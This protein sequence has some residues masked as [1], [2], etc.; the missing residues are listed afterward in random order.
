[1]SQM[2]HASAQLFAILAIAPQGTGW[3]SNWI[4]VILTNEIIRNK[5]LLRLM[6]S[7]KIETNDFA[8]LDK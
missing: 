2:T 6:F 4:E 8:K 7:I 1:M 5:P 3:E